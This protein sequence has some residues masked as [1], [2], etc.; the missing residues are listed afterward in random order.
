MAKSKE[1]TNILGQRFN[2][3]VVIE[4]LE[5]KKN[6]RQMRHFWLCQCDCGNIIKARHDHLLSGNTQSCGCF[7]IDRAIETSQRKDLLGM[8]FGRLT[9]IEESGRNA[10]SSVLWKCVCTCGN[11]VVVLSGSLLSGATTSCGCYGQEQR[12]KGAVAALTKHGKTGSKV[13]SAWQGMSTR[14][15]YENCVEYHNY[16]GRGITVCTRWRESFENFYADMGDPPS[17]EYSIDRIDN[18]GNYEPENCRWA[19][20]KEQSRNRQNN[21]VITFG[22][23]SMIAADW[24]E[25]LNLPVGTVYYRLRKG[26]SPEEILRVNK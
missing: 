6:G 18:D 17:K 11:E 10:L 19:T 24:A 9:V 2:R 22:G 13:Y 20:R 25:A 15:Y 12:T 4:R 1:I 8:V 23:L 14:C 21:R 26:L 7:K 16:G 3:L 5:S